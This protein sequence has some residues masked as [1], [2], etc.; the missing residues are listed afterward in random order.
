MYFDLEVTARSS[1]TPYNA[2]LNAIVG[3]FAQ[4]NLAP[5]THVDLRVTVKRSCSSADSCTL[6]DDLGSFAE[7]SHCYS[8]GC[9]CVGVTVS[10]IGD[11][12]EADRQANRLAYA[13][14]ERD[15]TL[16]LPGSALV[17]LS[18]YDFDVGAYG[19]YVE[20]LVL[21]TGW[22]YYVT[23]LRPLSGNAITTMGAL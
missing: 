6:C 3:K 7:R 14:A 17:G 13:C 18:V 11:C 23:P 9:S 8:L 16:I 21:G 2:S 19:E 4:I 22:A 10:R 20:Q 15:T 5:D 1:Y 12:T